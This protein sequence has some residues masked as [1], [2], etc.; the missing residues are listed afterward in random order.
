LAFAR[1]EGL[2]LSEYLATEHWFTSRY[3]SWAAATMTGIPA[4]RARVWFGITALYAFAGVALAVFMSVRTPG[5]FNN[6][7]ERELNVFSFLTVQSTL[8]VG[9]TTLMLAIKL[10]RI[11]IVFRAFRLIGLVTVTLAGIVYN[12]A[13]VSVPELDGWTQVG[14]QLLH[15]IMPLLTVVGWL[16]FGPRKVISPRIAWLSALFPFSWLTFTL[17]RG[18]VIHWYPYPFIDVTRIGY[19]KTIRDCL[20]VSLL[21]FGLAAGASALDNFLDRRAGTRQVK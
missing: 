9:A 15:T 2:L 3:L 4:M 19:V 16:M 14:H 18:A 17:V 20:F 12:V 11:S 8:I 6:G 1:R 7:I 21:L 13:L 5:H 10:D